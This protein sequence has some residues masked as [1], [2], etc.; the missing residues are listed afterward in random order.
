MQDL[1]LSDKHS[2]MPFISKKTLMEKYGLEKST[3]KEKLRCA[4][5]GLGR[6]GTLLEEDVLREKPCTHAGAIH[7]NSDTVLVGG[8]DINEERR[9]SFAEKWNHVPVFGDVEQLVESVHP[10]IVSVATPP[11]TH[12]SIIE[13]LLQTSVRLVI[14]EKP[15]APDSDQAMC[16]ARCHEQGM[17]KIMT[18]HERRYSEDYLTVQDHIVTGRFGR[19]L[20]IS[21]KV[22]MG[23][24]RPV[25]EMMLDDGTHLIDTLRFLTSSELTNIHA[26]LLPGNAAQTLFVRCCANEVPISMDFG[27]GRDHI[28]FELDLSFS[29]GRIRIGNGLYEEYVSSESPY[30]EHMKSLLPTGDPGFDQTGYFSNMLR[31]AVACVRHTD[32]EPRGT[33]VDGLRSIQFIDRV[34]ELVAMP[35]G[36]ISV[37]SPLCPC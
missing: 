33:A 12:L 26:E 29:A 5:V 19:L 27:S 8:C 36:A 30:Y 18:N 23:E 24:R 22:Y 25:L 20:S 16:I 7:N 9:R 31:D 1:Y 13:S 34:K 28:V 21:A 3:M 6:I 32:V 14:C 2:V 15:L 4:V 10:D 17:L 35:R 11:E 37:D